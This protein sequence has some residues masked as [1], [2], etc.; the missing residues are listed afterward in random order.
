MLKDRFFFP[1]QYDNLFLYLEHL[2]SLHFFVITV[3]LFV[4]AY[5]QAPPAHSSFLSF[6]GRGINFG[7]LISFFP[8][9]LFGNN[10][11]C[12]HFLRVKTSNINIFALLPCNNKTLGFNPVTSCQFPCYCPRCPVI[13]LYTQD[14]CTGST[15]ENSPTSSSSY[16]GHTQLARQRAKSRKQL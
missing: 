2:V 4:I 10:T 13:V 9:Y 3:D 11:F 1:L 16:G 14:W 5:V 12:G 6:F 7:G 15:G 8:F